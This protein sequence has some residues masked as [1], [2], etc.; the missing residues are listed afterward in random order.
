[1]LKNK[2]N[3][4]LPGV[5]KTP[6]MISKQ[7]CPGHL[8]FTQLGVVSAGKGKHFEWTHAK[9]FH[10]LRCSIFMKQ[11][12]RKQKS[13]L[14][15]TVLAF[16]LET[17]STLHRLCKPRSTQ[18]ISWYFVTPQSAASQ[19]ALSFTVSQTLLRLRVHRVGDAIQPSH[20]LSS[21]PLPAFSLS[22]HQGLFQRVGSS[23]QVAKGLEL[24][25]QHQSF[26]WIFR[27]DF[28]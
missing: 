25:L 24:Q 7:S 4:L 10:L 21:P 12:P 27:S 18:V 15:H 16:C 9:A 28:L 20:P 11:R 13:M 14:S 22:Q 17:P 8:I 2:R 6:L 26:Q 19:A 1:M 5:L 3:I 23:P